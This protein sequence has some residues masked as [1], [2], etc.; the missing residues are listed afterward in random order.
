MFRFPF[1]ICCPFSAAAAAAAADY[2]ALSGAA[3]A[4]VEKSSA[5]QQSWRGFGMKRNANEKYSG[6]QGDDAAMG[7][8]RGKRK[9]GGGKRKG[10]GGKRA[11]NADLAAGAVENLSHCRLVRAQVFPNH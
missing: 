10:G 2:L 5:Q 7:E 6:R 8:E 3:A 9:R 11:K 4:A 1:S